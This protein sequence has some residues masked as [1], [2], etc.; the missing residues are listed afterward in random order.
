M[1]TEHAFIAV[2][3]GAESDFESVLPEALAVLSAAPGCSSVRIL[4]GVERPSTF[5]LLV[6]WE[7]LA[8]H[9]EGFR[10]SEA[11]TRWR[12]LIGPY[13]DGQPEVEHFSPR[14]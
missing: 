7:S 4:R 13:L 8:A 1:V 2:L 10:S 12:A 14:A 11:F 5:L 9:T 6:E 3:P